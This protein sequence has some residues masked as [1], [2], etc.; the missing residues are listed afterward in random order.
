MKIR[1][2]NHNGRLRLR[3][4]DGVK[5][6]SLAIGVADSP[7]GRAQANIKRGEILRDWEAGYYDQT[8]VKYRPKTIGKNA[9]E[10]TAAELFDRFAANQLK[11]K[12]LANFKE[13]QHMSINVDR[14]PEENDKQY[15]AYTCY[16]DLG[17]SRSMLAAQRVYDQKMGKVADGREKKKHSGSLDGWAK[18]HHWEERA[19]SWDSRAEEFQPRMVR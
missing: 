1:I 15:L 12:G 2:N 18:T 8:L 14:L 7:V 6:Q 17:L 3:W 9:S 4:H 5:L 19:K 13:Q 11:Q 10:I 16:R